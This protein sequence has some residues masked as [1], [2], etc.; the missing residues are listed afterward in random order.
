M[1]KFWKMNMT[2]FLNL[3]NLHIWFSSVLDFLSVVIAFVVVPE[4]KSIQDLSNMRIYIIWVH[5]NNFLNQLKDLTFTYRIFFHYIVWWVP[6]LSAAPKPTK[7]LQADG[8][9]SL[10]L[11]KIKPFLSTL[12]STCSELKAYVTGKKMIK[13]NLNLIEN[14][15]KK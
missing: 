4:G 5:N 3:Q 9:P 13:N 15:R 8:I 11:D 10:F 2:I 7:D 6:K 14:N 1:H 12:F